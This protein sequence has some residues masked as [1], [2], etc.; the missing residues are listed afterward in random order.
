MNN[1]IIKAVNKKEVMN[2]WKVESDAF[3]MLWNGFIPLLN[4]PF[5]VWPKIINC[6]HL[7]FCGILLVEKMI[8]EKKITLNK[9]EIMN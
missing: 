2:E 9:I 3:T 6:E 1:Q 5:S 4:P 7:A 8:F